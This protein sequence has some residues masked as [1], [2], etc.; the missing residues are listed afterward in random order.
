MKTATSDVFPCPF[1]RSGEVAVIGSARKFLHYRCAACEEVWT[2]MRAPE[3][4]EKRSLPL[5]PSRH[6]AAKTRYH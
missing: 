3:P 1:C 2:A 5:A 4:A 6:T